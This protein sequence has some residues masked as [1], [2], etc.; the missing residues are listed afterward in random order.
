MM[1]RL[2]NLVHRMLIDAGP[3]LVLLTHVRLDLQPGAA[4]VRR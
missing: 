4:Q 1:R 2:L 3:G